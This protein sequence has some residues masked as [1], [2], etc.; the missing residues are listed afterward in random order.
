MDTIK[1]VDIVLFPKDV[2]RRHEIHAEVDKNMSI[3]VLTKPVLKRLRLV[4][5]P[6]EGFKAQDAQGRT[7]TPIGKV[8]LEWYRSPIAKQYSETF[9]V[10]ESDV[11]MVMMRA[12]AF[13]HDDVEDEPQTHPIGL[14][15]QTPEEQ[16]KQ[17]EKKAE[18]EERRAKEQKEQ[19]DRERENRSGR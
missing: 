14:Q 3:S 5:E 9:Y 1:G 7:W 8:N 12:N 17:A 18:A 15:K 16:K 4:C 13:P 11:E 10:V 19:E 6:C 2:E